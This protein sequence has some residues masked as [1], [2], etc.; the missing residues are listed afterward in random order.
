MASYW[1][2][3][4]FIGYVW[5]SLFVIGYGNMDHRRMVL[6][7]DESFYEDRLDF[8]GSNHDVEI[9]D[10]SAERKKRVSWVLTGDFPRLKQVVYRGSFGSLVGDITGNLPHLETMDIVCGRCHMSLNFQ[11]SWQGD[12][13]IKVANYSAPIVLTLPRDVGVIVRTKT[14]W[15]GSVRARG[16]FV[17][18]KGWWGAKTFMNQEYGAHPVTLIFDVESL[19]EGSIE[20][21]F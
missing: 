17:S 7:H 1:R 4:V 12:S 18:K 11:G 9:L 20:L 16:N 15:S 5:H 6:G 2:Y 14:S 21:I 10:I 3:F 8:S 13:H 19:G